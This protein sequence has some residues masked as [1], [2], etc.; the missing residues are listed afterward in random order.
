MGQ[1][2]VLASGVKPSHSEREVSREALERQLAR[3]VA[4]VESPEH[5][6]FGPSSA[7]WRIDRESAL[8]L[9]GGRAALLQLAHPYV[10]HAVDQHSKTKTDPL[11]RFQRTF[12]NVYA[13]VFGDLNHALASARRVHTMHTRIVGTIDEDVGDLRA[14]TPYAANDPEG[15]F[16]VHA[17]LIDSG[18]LFHQAVLGPLPRRQLEAYYGES[19]RFARLFGIPDEVMPGDFV[20]FEAYMARMLE[21]PRISVGRPAREI[22]SFLFR[23]PT[24]SVA[25]ALALLKLMTAGSLPPRLREAFGLRFSARHA[26]AYR[27]VLALLRRTY[28]RLPL[29]TR[30]VPAYQ[31]ALRRVAGKP[32]PDPV[33]HAVETLLQ[34]GLSHAL[35]RRA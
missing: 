16:W 9:G 35:P 7:S 19:K 10:A 8:F 1:I 31:H 34:R 25:P 6:V 27:A 12:N 24:R 18:L 5:G 17:T 23:P 28:P 32:G 14:G 30:T 3:L 22:A 15:L 13:M 20:A 11:G 21:S 4:E 33:A 2:L 29:R 26:R